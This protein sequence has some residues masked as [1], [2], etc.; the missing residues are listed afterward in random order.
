MTSPAAGSRL[1]AEP[2]GRCKLKIK[3][4]V[5]LRTHPTVCDFACVCDVTQSRCRRRQGRTQH[6]RRQRRE[7]GDDRPGRRSAAHRGAKTRSAQRGRRIK[8]RLHRETRPGC[9][10]LWLAHKLSIFSRLRMG[11]FLRLITQAGVCGTGLSFSQNWRKPPDSRR[12]KPVSSLHTSRLERHVLE[13]GRN[14]VPI[15]TLFISFA[16]KSSDE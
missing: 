14:H 13:P 5:N 12:K 8:H 1:W 10:A 2:R 16:V 9:H 7:P 15:A 6:E 4:T 3:Q 11:D